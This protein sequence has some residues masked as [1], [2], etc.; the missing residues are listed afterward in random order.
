MSDSKQGFNS[1]LLF[2]TQLLLS[3]FMCSYEPNSMNAF[4]EWLPESVYLC[5][6]K[7]TNNYIFAFRCNQTSHWFSFEN[8]NHYIHMLYV[9]TCIKWKYYE[10][11][12]QNCSSNP[13]EPSRLQAG[14]GGQNHPSP[15]SVAVSESRTL[16]KTKK[17]FGQVS[18][19]MSKIK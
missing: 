15:S 14:R 19:Y 16:F 1:L 9:C 10:M 8:L 4:E 17:H 6:F 7:D 2:F 5:P 11:I 3:S 13:K 18:V 12:F